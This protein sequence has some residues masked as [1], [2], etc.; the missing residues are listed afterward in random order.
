MILT[1]VLSSLKER[2]EKTTLTSVRRSRSS[3]TSLPR[4]TPTTTAPRPPSQRPRAS[5]ALRP[6]RSLEKPRR[7][8]RSG[9]SPPTFSATT[10]SQATI[11]KRKPLLSTS[12]S[13]ACLRTRPLLSLKRQLEPSTSSQP[14]SSRTPS[15]TFAQERAAFKLEYRRVRT[16]RR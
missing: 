12:K 7:P 10:S 15:R 8:P 3:A 9:S 5:A 11:S 13:R 1:Q 6:S 16:L 2:S 4:S 14:P